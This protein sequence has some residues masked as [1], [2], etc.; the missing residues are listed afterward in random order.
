MNKKILLLTAL[1]ALVLPALSLAADLPS[2]ARAA[3]GTALGVA[4]GVVV[5][6]WVVTGILFLMAA[7]APENLGKAKTALI[8]SVIGTVVVIVAN[9]ALGLVGGAFGI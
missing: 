1:G 2:M 7:G 6:M 4:T 3:A 9:G 8:A 5:V